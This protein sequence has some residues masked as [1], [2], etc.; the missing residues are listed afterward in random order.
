MNTEFRSFVQKYKRK[1]RR[2][3][4]AMV[5]I[6]VLFTA[7]G[8][9]IWVTGSMWLALTS[10]AFGLAVI[11]GGVLG[12]SQAD[13]SDGSLMVALIA[14]V[15]F[16]ILSALLIINAVVSPEDFQ[17]HR[18]PIYALIAGTLGLAFF[19]PGLI[20]LIIKLIRK[21][22]PPSSTPLQLNNYPYG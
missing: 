14:C 5:I 18:S 19:G 9:F 2:K 11:L 16:V 20:V 21:S 15:L 1:E 17:G 10:I 4:I 22:R 3:A 8:V 13:G 12:W 6:G 7:S